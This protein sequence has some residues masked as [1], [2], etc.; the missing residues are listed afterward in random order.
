MTSTKVLYDVN[1]LS[2]NNT[3]QYDYCNWLTDSHLPSAK[4]NHR[5][6][7]CKNAGQTYESEYCKHDVAGKQEHDHD[8]NWQGD[9]YAF[10][11]VVVIDW[12]TLQNRPS[13]ARCLKTGNQFW[14]RLKTGIV[15]EKVLPLTPN[16]NKRRPR[17]SCTAYWCH[18][19]SHKMKIFRSVGTCVET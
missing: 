8:C 7:K 9:C 10:E 19:K 3:Y 12:I 1:H 17:I 11:E 4:M 16:F 13:V 14:G 2:R 18:L 5:N 6:D 15:R